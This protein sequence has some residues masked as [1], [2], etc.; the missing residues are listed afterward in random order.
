MFLFM[1][2]FLSNLLP[3]SFF[4]RLSILNFLLITTA[5]V[6]SGFA[7]YHTACFLAGGL[8]DF[9]LAQQKRFNAT[10]FQY[11]LLFAGITVF[12]TTFIQF[13]FTKKVIQPVNELI[14]ATKQLKQGS[15]PAPLDVKT[16][17]E[18]KELIAHYNELLQ[19]LEQNEA[20]R[21]ELI[22]DDSHE[23]RT[24]IANLSG[25]MYALKSGTLEGTPEMFASLYGETM[26]LT[27]LVEQV[28]RLNEWT[29]QMDEEQIKLEKVSIKQ[30][31]L[32]SVQLFDLQFEQAGI[33]YDVH[34]AEA[35]IALNVEGMQQ[36]LTNLLA[37]AIQ[38][39]EGN[40]FVHITGEPIGGHYQTVVS[41]PGP[42][43]L[44]EEQAQL[45]D[46]FYRVDPSR[47]RDTGGNGLGLAIV[48]EIV[49]RHAGTIAIESGNGDN[50]FI[51]SLPIV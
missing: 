30:I 45:F 3:K 29:M 39:Y 12:A 48:K 27:K 41:S 26:R 40:G 9:T 38:Y 24:P 31:I 43:I 49:E 34:V 2:N 36:V 32:Q 47:H 1:S 33:D 4:W 37:N 23:L 18:M 15:Y 35:E 20:D 42:V 46:R 6:I 14:A 17:G 8:F 7:I 50:Q 16:N 44:P 22:A 51:I 10:L 13:H 21:D 5:I 28:E 11:L 25:Y 19:Q